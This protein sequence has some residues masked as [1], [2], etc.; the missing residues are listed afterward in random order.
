MHVLKKR[1]AL[2]LQYVTPA[3]AQ[4]GNW[5]FIPGIRWSGSSTAVMHTPPSLTLLLPL[6]SS[7]PQ[8]TICCWFSLPAFQSLHY[9]KVRLTPCFNQ[10]LIIAILL[11][12]FYFCSFVPG[13]PA[14]CGVIFLA[15]NVLCFCSYYFSF[16]C[17][18]A[19]YWKQCHAWLKPLYTSKD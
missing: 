10:Q 5:G 4:R 16:H 7:R 11:I 2:Y 9:I 1:L 14:H 6:C 8:E 19:C 15:R 18:Q 13:S 12:G 17:G 3:V